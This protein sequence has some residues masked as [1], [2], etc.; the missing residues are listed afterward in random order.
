M[1]I[2]WGHLNSGELILHV[3]FAAGHRHLFVRHRP[4]PHAPCPETVIVFE[5]RGGGAFGA[6]GIGKLH[7]EA[8]VEDATPLLQKRQKNI[9]H[10]AFHEYFTDSRYNQIYA[11]FASKWKMG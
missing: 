8:L 1:V 9:K 6:L 11:R 4:S 3:T 7:G 10:S 5:G 2:L